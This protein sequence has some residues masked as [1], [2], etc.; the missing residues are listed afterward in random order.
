MNQHE[1]KKTFPSHCNRTTCD[2]YISIQ[3]N[4]ENP[5]FLD[6]VLEASA[7]GWVAI[8]F[9]ST[10]GMVGSFVFL[11]IHRLLT[12]TQQRDADVLA[13]ALHPNTKSVVILDTYNTPRGYNN[14]EDSIQVIDLNH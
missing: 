3:T 2:Y 1:F 9:S 5:H 11:C 13:C 4:A 7:Q 10:P 6:F 8:G 14:V 12:P